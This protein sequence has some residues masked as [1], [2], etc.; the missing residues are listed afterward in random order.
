MRLDK[1]DEEYFLQN[2]QSIVV[3]LFLFIHAVVLNEMSDKTIREG[4]GQP[5]K[6]SLMPVVVP[7]LEELVKLS[8]GKFNYVPQ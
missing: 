3:N 8:E 7:P 5:L 2:L 6:E 4:F 1:N